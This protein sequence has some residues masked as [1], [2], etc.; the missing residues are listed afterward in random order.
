MSSD[1]IMQRV[2]SNSLESIGV[3]KIKLDMML[4]TTKGLLDRLD[5][6][7]T[8]GSVDGVSDIPYCPYIIEKLKTQSS[9]AISSGPFDRHLV[10]I[11]LSAVRAVAAHNADI[12]H[13][14]LIGL[15]D[16]TINNLAG[17]PIYVGR[18]VSD[19]DTPISGY[20]SK[21]IITKMTRCESCDTKLTSRSR[22]DHVQT[23]D[24]KDRSMVKALEDK[25]LCITTLAEQEAI[26]ISSVTP[27][28]YHPVRHG[29][30]VPRWVR[31]AMD[32]FTAMQARGLFQDL[33]LAEYLDQMSSQPHSP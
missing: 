13:S 11:S 19:T 27:R 22:S 2:K 33:T 10:E 14:I 4:L 21:Y 12:S 9:Y 26:I 18:I 24:C 28:E 31:Q 17:K 25:D 6:C 15:N 7:L 23:V 8:T 3:T 32:T 29:M 1:L 5:T 16:E 20:I 30:F